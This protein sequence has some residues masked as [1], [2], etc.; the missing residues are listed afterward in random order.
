MVRSRWPPSA[1]PSRP[2]MR[3]KREAAKRPGSQLLTTPTRDD[4]AVTNGA[5]GLWRIATHAVMLSDGAPGFAGD[6]EEGGG[7]D[8]E[9]GEVE[10]A[11]GEGADAEEV[12]GGEFDEVG[13]GHVHVAEVGGR[14]P[15]RAR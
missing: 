13:A 9:E 6:G 4:E 3:M 14:E 11:P 12:H 15:S 1:R 8:G 2:W 5:P 7:G 10:E